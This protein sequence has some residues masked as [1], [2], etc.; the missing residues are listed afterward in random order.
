MKHLAISFLKFGVAFILYLLWVIWLGN[1]WLLLGLPIIFDLYVSKKINW[2]FWKRRNRRNSIFIEWLDAILFA[3]IAVSFINIFFFQNY[4]I[5]SGSMEKSLLIGDHLYV[6]KLKYGPRIPNTPIGFPMTQNTLPFTINTKS[7]LLWP[8]WSYKRL[9][10]FAK[11]KNDDIVVFNYPEGDSILHD[12][13]QPYSIQS[14]YYTTLRNKSTELRSRDQIAGNTLKSQDEYES[15]ARKELVKTYKIISHPIDRE[16]NY[17][18]R[19]IAIPGDSLQI[20]DGK[21][22]INGKAQRQINNIQYNYTIFTDG[23]SISSDTFEKLGIYLSD[24]DTY[25]G[26]YSLTL[27]IKNADIIRSM[28]HVTS[29]TPVFKQKGDWAEYIFPNDQS[30]AWNEDQYGPLYVP[31]KG[32]TININVNNLCL[33]KRIITAYEGN[34]LKVNGKDIYIN[35]NLLTTYTFNMDYYFMMGD[36]RHNSADSRFWGFVPEDHIVGTPKFIWLSLDP[37]KKFPL[38][39]RWNRIF[40]SANTF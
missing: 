20:R 1:W 33:Y 29:V 13:N 21:V 15:N 2:T 37:T 38:N 6:S 14:D 19:C 10:G 23:K 32:K 25:Q 24:I 9:K 5:P 12:E 8:N 31:K 34:S 17:V 36:N 40:T 4:K 30:F 27:S 7:Y 16:D 18:K 11:I 26:G 3:V 22:Y 39:I 28:P 35:G